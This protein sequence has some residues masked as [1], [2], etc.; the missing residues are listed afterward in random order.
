MALGVRATRW[1]GLRAILASGLTICFLKGRRTAT[2]QGRRSVGFGPWGRFW[3]PR[4][5]SKM[6]SSRNS[7]VMGLIFI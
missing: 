3:D 5:G 4:A 2:S 1:V 7:G 6:D